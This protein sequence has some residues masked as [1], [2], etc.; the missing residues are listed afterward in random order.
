MAGQPK[1]MHI[2]DYGRL[3]VKVLTFEFP[4]NAVCFPLH[5]H[6]RIEILRIYDGVLKLRIGESNITAA[7]GDIVI[8]NPKQPH[9]AISENGGVHYGVIMT[10]LSRLAE[11]AYYGEEY[12]KPLIYRRKLLSSLV[13]DD[14]AVA[15]FDRIVKEN[16]EENTLAPMIIDSK[17][18]ELLYLLLSRYLPAAQPISSADIKFAEVLDYIDTHFSDELCI[19]ELAGKFGYDKSYFCRKFKSQ[20]GVTCSEYLGAIRLEAAAGM[21]KT[22]DCSVAAIA[23][24]C[25]Y[26]DANYFSR[27]FKKKYGVS[28]L[29]WQRRG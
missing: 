27:A 12:I 19:A 2:V 29:K 18:T 15:L 25:G 9:T 23:E 17:M 11:N 13:R 10:E 16:Q 8:I 28:P 1:E 6:D 4:S 3:P 5:W 24:K 7:S 14:E 22:G 26:K 21:L 20:T